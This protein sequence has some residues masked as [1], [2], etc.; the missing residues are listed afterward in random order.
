MPFDVR[1]I[2]EDIVSREGGFVDDP[3]DPGGATNHGVTIGTLRRLG[4]DLDG[5]GDVDALDVRALSR[6]Q[7]VEIFLDHYF[8]GPRIHTLPEILWDTVFDMY[9]NAGATAVKLLQ[10]VLRQMG[11]WLAVDGVIGPRTAACA[12]QAAASA[13]GKLRDAYGIARRNFY[14]RLADR[15]PSSRKYARTRA[16]GKGGWIRRAEEFLSEDYHLTDTEF[17]ERVAEWG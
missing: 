14:F 3:D 7:A 9:V 12:E 15:R 10:Q 2:A 17:R 6:P 13:P 16:G 4:Y 5:D 1:T 8:H 11:F